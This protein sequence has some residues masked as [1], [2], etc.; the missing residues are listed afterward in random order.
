MTF[1]RRSEQRAGGPT[2]SAMDGL[3][4]GLILRP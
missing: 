1:G 4:F 3:A 2:W